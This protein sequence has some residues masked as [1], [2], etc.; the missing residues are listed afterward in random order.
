MINLVLFLLFFLIIAFVFDIYCGYRLKTSALCK[1]R[2]LQLDIKSMLII[3]LIVLLPTLLITFRSEH[4]GIDTIR[5]ITVL[6]QSEK[7]LEYKLQLSGEYIYW[8]LC[9][10]FKKYGNVRSLFFVLAFIPLFLTFTSLYKLSRI[11]NPFVSSFL[12]LLFFYQE[13]FNATRQMPAIALVFFSYTFC[14]SRKFIPFCICVCL[15]AFF[16]STALV[17]FPLYFLYPRNKENLT[18][19]LKRILLPLVIIV[20]CTF[21]LKD[22]LSLD[23]FEKYESYS[24]SIF[25]VSMWQAFLSFAVSQGPI[26]FLMFFFSKTIKRNT[27]IE[28]KDISFLWSV[29][30]FFCMFL[31]LRFVQNWMFRLALYYQFAEILLISKI[32]CK[33]KFQNRSFVV[34][35]SFSQSDLLI[36]VVII[37]SYFFHNMSYYDVS[38]LTNFSLMEW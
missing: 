4:T 33:N 12:F 10:F 8:N 7:I 22:V 16:H 15:A 9:L 27:V 14:F 17:A 36:L 3:S 2:I 23:S 26:V 31:I 35:Y 6:E 19:H 37:V 13:C 38:A 28:D 25:K 24:D 5:Y 29:I 30:V 18:E 32:C 1:H 11:F 21:F 20:F 34:N